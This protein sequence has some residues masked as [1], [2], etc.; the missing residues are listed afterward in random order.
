MNR[1]ILAGIAA[2]LLTTAT[3]LIVGIGA[4]RAGERSDRTVEVVGQVASD[5]EGTT[6]TVLVPATVGWHGGWHGPGPGFLL[7]PLIVIGLFLL[8][9]SRRGGWHG[10]AARLLATTSSGE[11]HR[12]QHS[13]EPAARRRE[14]DPASGWGARGPARSLHHEDREPRARRRRRAGD[15]RDR[16]RL[17]GRRRVP[18]VDGPLRRRGVAPGPLDPAGSDRSRP[19]AAGLDGLDVARTIRQTSRVPIIMLTARSDEA[20]RVVGLELGA[21]DYLVKPFSPREL[22][23]RV[24]AVLRRSGAAAE[25]D[26]ERPLVVGELTV[27]PPRRLVTVG[28]R[29]V[30]MTATE[31]DLLARMA[32]APGRVFTAGSCWRRS[33]ASRSMPAN[34]R[35][36]PT[37]RTSVARSRPTHTGHGGSSPSTASAIAWPSRDRSS[38][39]GS[40]RLGTAPAGAATWRARPPGAYWWRRRFLRVAVVVAVIWIGFGVVFGVIAEGGGRWP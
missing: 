32:A 34:G 39:A 36:T 1:K 5:G 2:G 27:D 18:G 13:D 15:R 33:T 31:F 28:G 26:D 38:R 29:A 6:R 30:E 7:F 25:S 35:S 10:R 16:A 24:R 8:F 23:A 19:R 12:R 4:Y 37:S 9:A 11:W 40:G 17:P 21:D 22:L 14:I 20:D 3:L